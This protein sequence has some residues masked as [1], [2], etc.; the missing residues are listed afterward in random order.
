M[1]NTPAALVTGATGYLGSHL[2]R[3]LVAD[4]REVYAVV[5]PTSDRKR[6]GEGVTCFE[7]DGSAASCRNAVEKV[8]FDRAITLYHLAA[9]TK[10]NRDQDPDAAVKLVEANVMFGVHMIEAVRRAGRELESGPHV[11][12]AGSYWQ[13]EGDGIEG[14]RTLYAASKSAFQKILAHYVEADRLTAISLIFFD[15]YGERDWRKKLLPTLFDAAESES[16]LGLTPGLQKVDFV[17]VDDAVD[18]LIAADAV[19]ESRHR[20]YAVNSNSQV[21]LKELVA[22]VERVAGRRIEADWGARRYPA[23]QIMEPVSSLP[24]LPGWSPNV[25]LEQGLQRV[26]QSRQ[27]TTR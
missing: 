22:C 9:E 21:T 25:S 12:N 26:W 20:Q 2:V 18:A 5:R 27:S 3:R 6:L 8:G 14:V 11:V 24:R 16:K 1:S 19:R 10:L 7:Y 13:F 17:H 23:H 15:I 4:G